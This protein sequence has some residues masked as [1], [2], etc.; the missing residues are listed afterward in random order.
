MNLNANGLE[1]EGF[2]SLVVVL[3]QDGTPEKP[4]GCEVLLQFPSSPTSSNPF[5]FPNLVGDSGNSNNNLAGAEHSTVTP[6]NSVSSTGL[7]N[8]LG[9]DYKLTI[10]SAAAS[11]RYGLSSLTFPASSGFVNGKE[12]NIMAILTSRRGTD[13]MVDKFTFVT[14]P[15]A[16]DIT[17]TTTGGQYFINFNFGLN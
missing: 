15:V 3:A 4:A 9:N 12:V 10:G 5:S 7:N 11:G 6:L 17:I 1:E 16:S 13:V 14:P 8:N 2:I